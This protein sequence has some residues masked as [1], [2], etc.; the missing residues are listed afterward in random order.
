MENNKVMKCKHK[1]IC[2][3]E[4]DDK[5]KEISCNKNA[6]KDGYCRRHHPD[7]RQNRCIREKLRRAAAKNSDNDSE[8][9]TSSDGASDDT[10][11]TINDF[12]PLLKDKISNLVK[13]NADLKKQHDDYLKK[14]HDDYL[15][16]QHDDYL[17][18]QIDDYLKK[19]IDVHLK[20]QHDD[21]KTKNRNVQF[22][23]VWDIFLIM[24]I[25]AYAFNRFYDLDKVTDFV[26]GV[27]NNFT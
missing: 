24:A 14:Q 7:Y 2:R 13:E 4:C 16:K 20:K 26:N 3:K 8:T 1:Y 15:K 19:Q 10:M 9:T 21:Y 17:K 27:I 23:R 18:K 22:V 5:G 6:T 11:D 25:L 12:S